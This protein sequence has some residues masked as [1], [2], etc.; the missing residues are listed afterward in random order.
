MRKIWLLI[1]KRFAY[2]G[3][4][5]KIRKVALRNCGYKIGEDVYLGN[6]VLIITESGFDVKLSVGH[7]ASISPRVTFILASGSNNSRIR[8]KIPLK[9]GD[10]NIG[11]DAWIGTGVIIYPGITIGEGAVVAAGSVV[12]K[13]VTTNSVVGGTPAKLIKTL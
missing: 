11:N 12:T 5:N 7:R 6:E 13:D 2:F 1:N 8:V 4:T 3:I 9:A 10:I